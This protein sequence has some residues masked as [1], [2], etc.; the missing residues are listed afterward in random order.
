MSISS[1]FS[2]CYRSYLLSSCS[3]KVILILSGLWLI[4][5]S[6]L[7]GMEKETSVYST[8]STKRNKTTSLV[9]D[10]QDSHPLTRKIWKEQDFSGPLKNLKTE[11]GIIK[12]DIISQ[13]IN[14][15]DHIKENL[16]K[17]KKIL[18]CAQC[19]SSSPLQHLQDIHLNAFEFSIDRENP[20]TPKGWSSNTEVIIFHEPQKPFSIF[21]NEEKKGIPLIAIKNFKDEKN[22]DA[23]LIKG[24]EE[25]IYSLIALEMNPIPKQLKMAQI[26]DAVICPENSL[27]II[28]EAVP[29]Q[30]L[31][32]CLSTDLATEAVRACAEYLA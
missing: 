16:E 3:T 10:D 30:S 8:K 12:S 13:K 4:H 20:Q 11:I 21:K 1:S 22:K 2:T 29:G 9:K 25:L 24:L 17:Y 5:V 14:L 18:Q 19:K 23:G 7:K 28:M 26:F 31:H 32:S 27:S 6:P 15:K